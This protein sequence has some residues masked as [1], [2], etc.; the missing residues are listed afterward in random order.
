MDSQ[1]EWRIL[2]LITPHTYGPMSTVVV[3][4]NSKEAAQKCIDRIRK[5][6]HDAYLLDDVPHIISKEA[7]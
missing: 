4:F 2:I 7:Q 6:T 1:S 5:S 3:S